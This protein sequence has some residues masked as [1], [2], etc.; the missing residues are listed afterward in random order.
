MEFPTLAGG[1]ERGKWEG[2]NYSLR[3]RERELLRSQAF[4]L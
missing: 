1:E 2:G 3:E 4:P